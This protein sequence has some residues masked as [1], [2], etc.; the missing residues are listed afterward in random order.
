[1]PIT[2]TC[3]NCD[4]RL[5]VPD[6]VLGKKIRCKKCDE[7]FV[8]KR[9]SRLDDEDD[10]PRKPAVRRRDDDEPRPRGK[11]MGKSSKK[12][13]GVPILVTLI[14]IGAVVLIG[15]GIAAYFLFIKE[16]KPADTPVAQ[17][18]G[19]GGPKANGVM[20]PARPIVW[21]DFTAPD[22][23]FTAKFP[24][25][26]ARKTEQ[27]QSDIGPIQVDEHEADTGLVRANVGHASPTSGRA[28]DGVSLEQIEQVLDSLCTYLVHESTRGRE[29]SRKPIDQD[30]RPGREMV[31][32]R[33]GGGGG[34]TVRVFVGKGRIWIL[35][36]ENKQ[37]KPDQAMVEK[38]FQG[39]EL[40]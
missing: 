23:S 21:V 4:A 6:T 40:K 14:V 24:Q 11:R 8:A 37:T 5:S 7:P 38:F 27:F 30:G 25:Q 29:V 34:A 36:I 17:A 31:V 15:G 22:K 10:R 13:G 9:S 12:Q 26:P 1:M 18:E 39:F 19:A 33:T 16:D 35:F 20:G 3:P 2:L 32:E 28:I